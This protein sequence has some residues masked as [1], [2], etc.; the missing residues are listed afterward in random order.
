MCDGSST[1]KLCVTIAL[2]T[3]AARSYPACPICAANILMLTEAMA[4]VFFFY[5][6]S[7]ALLYGHVACTNGLT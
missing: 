4:V 3:P 5:Q 1:W 2:D 6:N 7:I